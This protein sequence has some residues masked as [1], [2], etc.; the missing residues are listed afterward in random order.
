MPHVS[1]LRWHRN[2]LALR[3]QGSRHLS[4]LRWQRL[5]AGP[6]RSLVTPELR[7]AVLLRDRRCV[8]SMMD[9]AHFCYDQW[10]QVH[11]SDDLHRLTLEHVKD[12][13]RMGKRAPSDL[14]HLVALC[15]YRNAIRPPTKVERAWMR[16]Y[17][18]KVAA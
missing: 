2:G 17:L 4:A 13:L 16:E 14:S 6:M 10:G 12:R 9:A 5:G 15:G 3:Y 8:L 1:S 18:M 11:H 7:E